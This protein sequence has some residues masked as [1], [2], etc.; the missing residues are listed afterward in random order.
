MKTYIY[1][2]EYIVINL[3][4]SIINIIAVNNTFIEIK[5][6]LF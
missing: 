6:N 4:Y 3:Y 1:L 2:E 5:I